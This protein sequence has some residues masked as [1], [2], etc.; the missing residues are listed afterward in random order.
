MNSFTRTETEQALIVIVY[1]GTGMLEACRCWGAQMLKECRCRMCASSKEIAHLYIAFG[2]RAFTVPKQQMQTRVSHKSC[3][4]RTV[5]YV[6]KTAV[7]TRANT[8]SAAHK[9]FIRRRV[10]M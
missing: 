10:R 5:A 7:C 9:R 1:K 6:W 3:V 4:R 2:G 8:N